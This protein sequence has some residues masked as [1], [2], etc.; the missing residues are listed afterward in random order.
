MVPVLIG[1]GLTSFSMNPHAIP[2]VRALIRHL[3]YREAQRIAH[4]AV[5]LVTARDVEE[6]LLERL[7]FLLARN[8]IHV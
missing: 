7:A 4:R 2:V 3:S 1:L 8:K 6:H 5:R